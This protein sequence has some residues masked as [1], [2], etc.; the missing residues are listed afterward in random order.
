[1]A[2]PRGDRSVLAFINSMFDQHLFLID[3]FK[4]LLP[5]S[6]LIIGNAVFDEDCCQFGGNFQQN[7][8]PI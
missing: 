8:F 5:A 1:M 2:L 7:L 6:Q 4:K 3:C